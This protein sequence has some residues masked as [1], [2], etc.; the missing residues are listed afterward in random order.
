MADKYMEDTE[1]EGEIVQFGMIVAGFFRRLRGGEKRIY[2]GYKRSKS[3]PTSH[4][5][6]LADGSVSK[7]SDES[8]MIF[9]SEEVI[10]IPGE[11]LG[12]E[13]LVWT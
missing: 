11:T 10:M 13:K 9:P 3:G 12:I 5:P 1:Q 8:I 2:F 7:H 4:F 6:V